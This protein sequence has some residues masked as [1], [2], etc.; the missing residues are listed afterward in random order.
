MQKILFPTDFST[1]A[2]GALDYAIEMVNHFKGTLYLVSAYKVTSRGDMF[3]NLERYLVED[4][5]QGMEKMRKLIEPKL[6]EGTQLVTEGLRGDT[7]PAIVSFA[8]H[9]KVDYI[10]MGTQ[11]ASGLK[12]VFMGSTT[13]GV[14]QATDIPVLAIPS[15]YNIRPLDNIVFALDDFDLSSNQVVAPLA[16]LAKSF[17]ANI[18]IYH[19]E[20][21]EGDKGVDPSVEIFLDGI[22]HSYHYE[23]KGADINQSIRS[24]VNDYRGDLLCMIQRERGFIQKLL[25]P[26]V[27][28]REIFDS[29]VPLLILHDETGKERK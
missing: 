26:S 10:V 19:L 29:Q 20:K 23:L 6:A 5:E 27:T 13:G 4:V 1:H 8:E 12:E 17:Q 2:Q 3:K 16:R 21:G 11:G 28:R 7:V 15:G 14:I 18:L 25:Q 9:K 22:E 24:F